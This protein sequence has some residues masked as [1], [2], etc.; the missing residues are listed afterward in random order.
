MTEENFELEALQNVGTG[1]GVFDVTGTTIKMKFLNAGYYQMV[2]QA[3]EERKQ[4]FGTGTLMAV[5]P[6]DRLGLLNE[7]LA[8]IREK[9]VFSFRFRVLNGSGA[10]VWVG[11]KANHHPLKDGTERFYAAYYNLD[12]MVQKQN[13]LERYS[14]ERDTILGKI[15]GGVAIFSFESGEVRLNYTN[16]GFYELHHG[17][18]KYWRSQSPNPVNWLTPEDRALFNQE[19]ERVHS[20]KQSEGNVSYRVIGEDGRLHWVNN[21]F[22]PAYVENGISYYYAS[23]VDLDSQKEAEQ[24]RLKAKTMYEAAVEEAK[25][26][27]WE[28]D[29]PARR[30]T[31]A[32]NEFTSYDYRKFGLPHVI[33]HVPDALLPY[34]DESSQKSFLAVY[35]A[36]IDGAPRAS[37]EVWYKL[38]PGVEPRCERISYTTVYDESGKPVK[39]FGIGQNI[40]AQK[41]NE[42]EYQRIRDQYIGNLSGAVSSV[43]FNLSRNLYVMGYSPYP[44]VLSSLAKASADEHFLAAISAVSDPKRKAELQAKFTCANLLRL[45]EKG[46]ANQTEEYPIRSSKG[47]TMWIRTT[48]AM[49]QNPHS[50]EIEGISYSKDITPE[51]ENEAILNLLTKEGSDFVGVIDIAKSLFTMHDGVWKCAEIANGESAPLEEIRERLITH[52]V[53]VAEQGSLAKS[54][55]LPS[56]VKAL[57]EKG[58]LVLPYDFKEGESG[59]LLKKQISF[60]FMEPEEEKILVLQQDVTEAYRKDE[61]RMKEL[62]EAK[63]RADAANVAKSEFLSQM[64][65]DIR[66][67]LNGIIGMNYLASE[68][69]NPPKTVDCLRKIETSSKYLLSLIND[70]LDI[71]KAESN[72]IEFRLEPYPLSEFN[73]YVDS[74]IKPLCQA[75]DQHFT[76]NEDKAEFALV[77][78]SD[79]LRCNQIIFNLLSNA[80]KYTPEGGNITY[81]ISGRI[82][83]PR[84]IEITHKISDDGIGMSDEFQKHLFQPFTQENRLVLP[85]AHGTGL[86]LAIVKKLVD[87]MGGTIAVESAPGKGSTFTVVLA[88]DAVEEKEIP[89]KPTPNGA[90]LKRTDALQGKR[91]LLCEDNALNQEIAKALL[92]EK[93][94]LVEVSNNGAEG[95]QAFSSSPIGYY[96]GILMDVHMPIMDGYEATR[97][98]RALN[99][100]DALSVPILA[101]TADAFAEDIQKAHDA[102]MN[103]HIAKPIDPRQVIQ[104]LLSFLG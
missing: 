48:V 95:L 79:K 62:E 9:R 75:K 92:A 60:R 6:N 82:L 65:H 50:G 53:V 26:V 68:Q 93:G 11:I 32:E 12:D 28:F 3:R 30:I 74:L 64:S 55:A 24:E 42:E 102:G 52:Y 49:M 8:S 37:C 99:R 63:A 86:G 35:E 13:A 96:D 57:K 58:L 88:F 17:S 81:S 101:M 34:I 43:Q 89:A 2:G 56:L 5:H 39:A 14:Q 18:E 70:I 19:F 10:Y 40:T 97:A 104:T 90:L 1:I 85:E 59:P 54:L 66:T 44:N 22:R 29:I 69:A 76:L 7:A 91:V 61:E 84:R 77:P 67:P 16:P 25:L 72:K 21:Q 98:I 4:F 73:A 51:K 38:Q 71:S 27:V 78:L 23:F 83:G 15:P 103:G 94:V 31:M 87:A 36:I 41:R 100:C 47:E 33:D 46:I 45:F 80:V 20:G